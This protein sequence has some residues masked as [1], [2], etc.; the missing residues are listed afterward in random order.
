M[1][2]EAH[3]MKI[4]RIYS[5][6]NQSYN[7]TQKITF[8]SHLI[9]RNMQYMAAITAVNSVNQVDKAFAGYRYRETC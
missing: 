6:S 7:V 9:N 1:T 2:P 3:N 5:I 4:H 8:P